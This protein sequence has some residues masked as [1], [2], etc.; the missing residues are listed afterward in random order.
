MPCG[1]LQEINMKKLVSLALVASFIAVTG[2][3][4]DPFGLNSFVFPNQGTDRNFGPVGKQQVYNAAVRVLTQHG[5][6]ID[7]EKSSPIEGKIVCHP[8]MTTARKDRVAGNTEA[9]KTARFLISQDG[10]NQI[11]QLVVILQRQAGNLQSKSYL[12]DG[13]RLGD[14]YSANPGNTTPADQG[15]A[16]TAEQDQAWTDDRG[17]P[18]EEAKML[19]QIAEMLK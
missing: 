10:Q 14:N 1:A 6:R 9:R 7:S 19:Q 2:C 15:A 4:S 11:G 18:G 12:T 13:E 17:M 5:Y 8:K 16:V 3:G